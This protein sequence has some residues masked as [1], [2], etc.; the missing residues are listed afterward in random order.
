[1]KCCD[2]ISNQFSLRV[3]IVCDEKKIKY[4][5]LYQQGLNI[6]CLI[7]LIVLSHI[8][9]HIINRKKEYKIK[10]IIHSFLDI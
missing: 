7:I 5:S 1:M 6:L 9:K 8:T 10:D 3:R 4:K 2:I